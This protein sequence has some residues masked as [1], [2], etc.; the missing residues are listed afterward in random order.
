MLVVLLMGAG[1]QSASHLQVQICLIK[2]RNIR[3]NHSVSN[4][5]YQQQSDLFVLIDICPICFFRYGGFD[6]GMQLPPDL[7]TD[8][9]GVPKNR[10]LSKVT[11]SP[12]SLLP[13]SL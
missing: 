9:R 8:L 13:V 5:V 11:F 2:R 6:F 10:T 3:K 7:Q 1:G 4:L 12:A